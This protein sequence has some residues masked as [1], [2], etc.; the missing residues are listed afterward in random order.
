MGFFLDKTH[1]LEKHNGCEDRERERKNKIKKRERKT[2]IMDVIRGKE[3]DT[4]KGK[5]KKEK[6]K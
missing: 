5:K 4:T 1:T 2:E 3:R 6:V